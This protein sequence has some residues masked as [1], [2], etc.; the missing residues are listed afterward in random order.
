MVGKFIVASAVVTILATIGASFLPIPASWRGTSSEFHI[1]FIIDTLMAC[2]HI[3]AAL[4]FLM[5]LG[6]YKQKMRIAYAVVSGGLILTALGT[7]QLAVLDGF[8][9]MDSPWSMSGGVALPFLLASLA[10]YAGTRSYGKLVG[11]TSL[12][13]RAALVIPVVLLG[14][15]LFSLLPHVA[16]PSEIIYDVSN[17]IL[18]WSLLLD[19]TAAYIVLRVRQRIGLHYKQALTWLA[20]ALLGSSLCLVV[21]VVQGVVDPNRESTDYVVNIL[22][23]IAG[24]LWVRA[25]YSFTRTRTY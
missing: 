17:G 23:T 13:T 1:P 9:L 24:L 15:V 19:V 20:V 16:V 11:S 8:D 4:L 5:T 18:V 22:A 14:V 12:F 3:C 10:Y 6:A 7:L 21:A 25:G 2:L